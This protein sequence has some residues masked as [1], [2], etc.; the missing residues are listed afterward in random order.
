MRIKRGGKKEIKKKRNEKETKQKRKDEKK[1]QERKRN[2]KR[3][4]KERKEEGNKPGVCFS[5]GECLAKCSV[6]EVLAVGCFS[7]EGL[8][9]SGEERRERG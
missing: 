3:K 4:R 7:I 2:R 1:K 9:C 6:G 5:V 8:R